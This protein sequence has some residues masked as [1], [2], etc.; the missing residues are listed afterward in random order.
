M[1]TITFIGAGSTVFTRN[2][3]GD[4]LNREALSGATIRLMDIDPK[5]LAESEAVV[6]RMVAHPR[7]AGQ[8]RDACRPARRPSTAPISSSS[9]SRSAA[10]IP[11]RSPISRCPNASACARPSPTRSGSAGSCGACGPCRISGRSA[12]TCWRSARRR[13]CC[14]TSTRWRSTPGRSA[15]STPRSARSA[16]AIR[17]RERRRSWRRISTCRWTSCATARPGSTTWRSI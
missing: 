11:A 5:R 6:G 15:R 14:N 2:I 10:T 3:A 4:I 17:C 12:R 13:S 9:A 1:T 8:G 7:R 16:S